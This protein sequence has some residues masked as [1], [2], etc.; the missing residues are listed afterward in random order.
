MTYSYNMMAWCTGKDL[1]ISGNCLTDSGKA[2]Q[3]QE[4]CYI[5]ANLDYNIRS[6]RARLIARRRLK[7]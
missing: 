3:N 4:E 6:K 2:G 7:R 5:I 1:Y